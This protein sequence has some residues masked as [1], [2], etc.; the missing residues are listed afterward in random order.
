MANKFTNLRGKVTPETRLEDKLLSPNFF[1]PLLCIK[2]PPTC[3]YH[4]RTSNFGLGNF[5][6]QPP[7][8]GH[9]T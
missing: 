4:N 1:R 7:V 2:P 8:N 3:P 5:I 9:V 6:F